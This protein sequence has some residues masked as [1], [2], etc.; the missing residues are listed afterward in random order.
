MIHFSKIR[1]GSVRRSSR[2][3]L[4]RAHQTPAIEPAEHRSLPLHAGSPIQCPRRRPTLKVRRV[5]IKKSGLVTRGRCPK[6]S[7]SIPG[8]AGRAAQSIGARRPRRL[9]DAA[10][11]D[12]AA[13]TRSC[14]AQHGTNVSQ[15]LSTDWSAPRCLPT[16]LLPTRLNRNARSRSWSRMR[17]TVQEAAPPEAQERVNARWVL[18]L[19]AAGSLNGCEACRL[20][21]WKRYFP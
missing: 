2:A 7:P 13:Y 8:H 20:L 10:G 1:N 3:G 6:A 17:S 5:R 14:L 4:R 19:R 11:A 9:Q 15:R 16:T 12:A 18:A 21:P